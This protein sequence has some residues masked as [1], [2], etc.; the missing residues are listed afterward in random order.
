VVGLHG[1]SDGSGPLDLDV[2]GDAVTLR[3]WQPG[4]RFRPLGMPSDSK[5]QNLFV[6]RRVPADERRA[7]VVATGIGGRIFW[8]EGLPPGHRARVTARTRRRLDWGWKRSGNP[9]GA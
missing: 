5:L 9:D 6:N 3:H 7:R 4:D 2:V 8:V 1:A